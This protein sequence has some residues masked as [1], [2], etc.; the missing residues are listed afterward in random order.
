LPDSLRQAR[1]NPQ[2]LCHDPLV[3]LLTKEAFGSWA[4]NRV[5]AEIGGHDIFRTYAQFSAADG[6]VCAEDTVWLHEPHSFYVP[7]PSTSRGDKRTPSFIEMI[8]KQRQWIDQLLSEYQQ[9]GF[10]DSA[11]VA[12]LQGGL[13]S[14]KPRAAKQRAGRQANGHEIAMHSEGMR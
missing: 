2:F 3:L 14:D 1:Y 7:D 6:C 10:V 13:L 9:A 5:E 8:S 11:F 4:P 12:G